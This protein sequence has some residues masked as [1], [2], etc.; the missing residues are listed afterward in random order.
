LTYDVAFE[1]AAAH[2][3]FGMMIKTTTGVELAGGTYP[4]GTELAGP[5]A[6]GAR[7]RLRF[8]FSCRLFPGTYFMNAG[9]MGEVEGVQTY[10]HRL[11]D[12]L[13]FRVLP[14]T[15]LRAS[16]Y[17]DLTVDAAAETLA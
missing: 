13:A 12:A 14:E 11:V 15:A 5:F 4:P 6:P 17:V 3:R 1:K 10:L 8:A 9:L 7:L 16:G 2:V